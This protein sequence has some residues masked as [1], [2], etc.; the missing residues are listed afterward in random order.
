MSSNNWIINL[1]I[2]IHIFG[3]FSSIWINILK[4]DPIIPDQF[5]NQKLYNILIY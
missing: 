3:L 5:F 4:G 2:L 1:T